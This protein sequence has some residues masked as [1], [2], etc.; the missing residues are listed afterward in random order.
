MTAPQLRFL[1]RAR[2]SPTRTARALAFALL[3]FAGHAAWSATATYVYDNLGRLKSVT[4]DDST[5]ITYQLDG[6]GNRT[7]ITTSIPDSVAPNVPTGLT[8]TA[9]SPTQVSLSWNVTSDNSGG[10]GVTG[11]KIFRGGS[12]I[13]TSSTNS[14]VDNTAA[15]S[16]SYSYTVAAVD[17]ASNTSAQSTAFSITTPTPPDTTPPSAPTTLTASAPNSNEVDLSWGPSTDTGGSGLAGYKV[18]RNG[19]STPLATLSSTTYKDMTVVGTTA[20]TYKVT[21]YDNSNNESST[22]NTASLT[23]PDTIAPSVPT[24]LAKGAVTASQVNLSWN[25][26]TDTGGSALAGYRVYR[27]GTQVGTSA[28]TSYADNTVSGSTTYTYSVASYDNAG[29]LSAQSSGLSVSTTDVTPPGTPTN[30][31]GSVISPTRIDL[32]WLGVTDTGG[33]GLAGYKIVRNGSQVGTTAATTFSDTSVV[34]SNT[35]TYSIVAY[36]GQGNNSAASSTVTLSTPDTTPPGVP[37]ITSIGAAS[38]TQVNIYWSAVADNSGGSGLAGYTLYRDGTLIATLGNGTTSYPDTSV[39]GSTTYSYSVASYDSV[40]NASAQSS[41]ASVTTPLGIP[42]AP[43]ITNPNRSFTGSA[44]FSV[45]WTTS[46]S[47]TSYQLYETNT[48]K[49]T[50]ATLVYTGSAPTTS[51]SKGIGDWMYQVSACNS[52]GCSA[53]S[54]P[55]YV[56]ICGA[57]NGC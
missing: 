30:L 29:N 54:A 13:G 20:Y 51:R 56:T 19:A 53:L 52:V 55:K 49:T 36:D 46:S 6:A 43:T 21:A 7:G 39:N 9:P 33:S 25:A 17:A 37:A 18:Y 16:T 1:S 24:G 34:N 31:S 45:S 12:Q 5:S 38:A 22:S 8:G 23:T 11:Y 27:N 3:A 48:N 10:S 50:T 14:Y 15:G 47:A 42:V 44:T 2:W 35:Y 41:P 28:S 26:A 57:A 4:Y 32:A 40:G